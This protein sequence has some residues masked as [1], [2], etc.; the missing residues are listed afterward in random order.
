MLMQENLQDT[1]EAQA[2][3][4]NERVRTRIFHPGDRVLVLLPSKESKLLAQWQGPYEVIQQ[5]GPITYE[6]CQPVCRKTK[7]IYINLLKPWHKWEALM[8]MP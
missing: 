4:Y 5:T 7:E 6:I 1:Q 3:A 8:I 2:Q